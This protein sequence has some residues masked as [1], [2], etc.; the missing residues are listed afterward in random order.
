MNKIID[1]LRSKSILITGASGL[2]CSS[3]IDLLMYY[4]KQGIHISIYAMSRNEEYAH[5]RFET[6]WGNPL[7]TFIEHDV[8]EP[9][10]LDL[11]LDYIIHGA[12]NASPKRYT[13]DPVGT[14]KSNLWGVSNLLELAKEKK[15]R[16]LYISSGEVYGEG[17]GVDFVEG[18]SGYVDCLNPRACYPSSKRAS[19]TLCVSYKEQYGVDVVIARPGHIYGMDTDRDD[20]AFAQFL[21][22]AKKNA[23][24]V[25]KSEGCQVRSYCY[26]EDCASALLYILLRG[27]NGKAYNIANSDSVLS[28]KELAELIAQA[29]GVKVMY[30]I[31]S[32]SESKGYSKVQR[33]VLDSSLLES[34]GWKP[35][36]SLE[37]GLR[38][39][40]GIYK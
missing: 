11:S 34:L 37:E 28:I 8:I 24:V 13:T 1:K 35:Q 32:N 16:L 30:D 17:G 12:S 10:S 20:R 33:A 4:N 22:N 27:I 14:M 9:F 23:N 2:I 31:P 3:F 29:A 40:L 18:Y 25:M 6:Y 39:V 38:R 26:V 7:F 36:V 21:R 15:A 5:K 19:E